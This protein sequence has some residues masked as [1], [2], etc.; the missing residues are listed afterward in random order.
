MRLLLIIML[1]MP[2]LAAAGSGTNELTTKDLAEARNLYVGKCAK[3]HRFYEPR[4]YSEINW[5][6]WMIKMD[7]KSK[8]NTRQADLLKTYLDAYRAGQ[9]PGKPQDKPPKAPPNH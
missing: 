9:L 8:L 4:N 7:Q 6:A 2:A 5:Q 1:L 3:C